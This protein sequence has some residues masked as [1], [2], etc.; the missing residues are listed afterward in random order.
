MKKNKTNSL[1]PTR[2]SKWI[3]YFNVRPEIAK[4]LELKIGEKFHDIGLG[5]D[6]F[7]FFWISQQKH[8]QQKQN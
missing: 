8:K 1:H 4:H 2:H 7:F 6:F 5:S 3:K